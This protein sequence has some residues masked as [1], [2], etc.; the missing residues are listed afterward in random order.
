MMTES[1]LLWDHFFSF[2][3]FG[4][5]F[6]ICFSSCSSTSLFSELKDGRGG[7]SAIT[8]MSREIKITEAFEWLSGDIEG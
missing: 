7:K 5:S 6:G 2:P 3:S 4:Y 8:L 1:D